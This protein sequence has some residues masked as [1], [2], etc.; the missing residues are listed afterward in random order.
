MSTI[1]LSNSVIFPIGEQFKSDN[2]N[3]TVWLKMLSLC[4]SRSMQIN[5]VHWTEYIT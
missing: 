1:D 4:S 5:K 3:G 2:F